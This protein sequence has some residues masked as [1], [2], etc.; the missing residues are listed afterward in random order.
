VSSLYWLA[1][2]GIAI[3][4]KTPRSLR[5]ALGSGISS[6]S[7]LGWRSKRLVTRQNMAR[8]LGLPVSDP[9][10]RHAA[11]ASWSNYGR[12]ASD[13]IYFPHMNMD[14]ID[15]R[16][17][18]QTQGGTWQDLTRQALEPGKGAIIATAHFGSWDI[19]GAIFARHFPLS[20]IAETFKDPQFNALM[21]G[22]RNEKQMGIIPMEHAPRRVLQDLRQNR[23][24]A[25]VVDRPM[26]KEKGVAVTFFGQETY[27]AGGPATLA[28]KAGAAILPGFVWYGHNHH[29]YVRAFAPIYPR[30]YRGPEER[31]REIARLTQAI[32]TALEEIVR[33]WP[34]QWFMFRPFWPADTV[35]QS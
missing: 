3:A 20:A 8:V 26:S 29:F 12:T 23:A 25:I 9:R 2:S 35:E 34:T 14:D 30:P 16:I 1:R 13:L 31:E 19:A 6:A 27:V 17:L 32:Y 33:E 4:G 5:Y 18:D 24:V 11:L 10:V 28:L 7:Y 22:H 15:A 21:Q